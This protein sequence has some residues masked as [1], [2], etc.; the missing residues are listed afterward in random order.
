MDLAGD[1]IQPST[2]S[3]SLYWIL[4]WAPETKYKANHCLGTN[5]TLLKVQQYSFLEFP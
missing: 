5:N 1:T 2:L 3:I 4:H